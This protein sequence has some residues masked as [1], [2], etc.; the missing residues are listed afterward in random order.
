MRTNTRTYTHGHANVWTHTD[1]DTDTLYPLKPKDIEKNSYN[2]EHQVLIPPTPSVRT[3]SC[4]YSSL[5]NVWGGRGSS[6][7]LTN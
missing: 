5:I 6:L 7:Y 1:M 2:R 3:G 4:S